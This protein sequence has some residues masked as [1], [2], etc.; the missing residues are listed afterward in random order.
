[1]RRHPRT[2]APASAI[3]DRGDRARDGRFAVRVHDRL[4]ASPDR[5]RLER[6]LALL[7]QNG[8]TDADRR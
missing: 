5:G 2:E 6:L 4:W 1:M 3:E 8:G 7:G